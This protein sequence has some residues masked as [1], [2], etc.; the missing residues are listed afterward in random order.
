MIHPLHVIGSSGFIGRSLQQTDLSSNLVLWSHAFKADSMKNHFDLLDSN[1]WDSLCASRPKNV[2]LL[3]WPGL[4]NYQGE[5]HL[6]ENLTQSIHLINRLIDVGCESITIAGTCYEYGMKSGSLKETDPVEPVNMYGI[7]KDALRRFV[8]SKCPRAGVRWTWL[9]IFY[10]YGEGQN[11]K[12]LYPS[13]VKAINQKS[14]FFPMSSGKQIRDFVS[15][16]Y[17][18]KCILQ[19]ASPGRQNGIV[20]LGSGKPVSL[21]EFAISVVDSASSSIQ[22]K[23]GEYEDRNDEPFAFWADTTKLNSILSLQ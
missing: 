22:L 3:S 15:A 9:R 17:L 20:N 16:H 2:L 19:I 23:L 7:A 6:T 1:T 14:E 11:P 13:L 12:S 4:P 18:A 8:A 21:K 5:F 10:P